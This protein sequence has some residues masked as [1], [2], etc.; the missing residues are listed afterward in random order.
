MLR[1][2]LLVS[3]YVR[4]SVQQLK[5]KRYP[6]E[7]NKIIYLYQKLYEEWNQQCTHPDVIIDAD[8]SS[9]SIWKYRVF[10]LNTATAYGLKKVKSG[11]FEWKLQIMDFRYDQIPETKPKI[12]FGIIDTKVFEKERVIPRFDRNRTW[13]VHGYQMDTFGRVFSY[14]N[15]EWRSVQTD[16]ALIFPE[17]VLS[18]ILNLEEYTLTFKV[19]EQIATVVENVQ[20]AEYCFAFTGTLNSSCSFSVTF[21]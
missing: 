18:I 3:G 16:H 19:N 10:K 11:I 4:N 8:D 17:M 13:F 9:R 15:Q 20:P 14:M 2:P 12:A 7:I 6:L 21:V 1:R 5:I